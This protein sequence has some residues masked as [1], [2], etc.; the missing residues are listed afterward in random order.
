MSP[1]K[2]NGKLTTG[3][4][5]AII[6]LSMTILST[7]AFVVADYVQG[8]ATLDEIRR[9]QA[10]HGETIAVHEGRLSSVEGR[11]AVLDDRYS[12]SPQ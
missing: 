5:V 8:R 6:G 11:V 10:R 3:A 7:F 12:R 2:P 4:I 1:I 9:T